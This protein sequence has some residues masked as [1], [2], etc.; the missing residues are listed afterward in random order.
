MIERILASID[1][2]GRFPY[3]GHVGKAWGTY[4]WVVTGLPYIVVY[5]ADSNNNEL[6]V[7]AVFHD[8]Q[9]RE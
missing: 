8:A 1:Q 6:K 3:M 2:L 5:E 9:H 4:E 7:V